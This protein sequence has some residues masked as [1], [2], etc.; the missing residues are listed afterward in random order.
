MG[1]GGIV[2]NGINRVSY[3]WRTCVVNFYQRELIGR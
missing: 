1:N 2:S 3:F